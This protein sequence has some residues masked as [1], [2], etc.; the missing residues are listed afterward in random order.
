[1]EFWKAKYSWVGSN[2][3]RIWFLARCTFLKTRPPW[4]TS[5]PYT[6]KP[7]H[8]RSEKKKLKTIDSNILYQPLPW[9]LNTEINT[10]GIWCDRWLFGKYLLPSLSP[11]IS[12]QF[13]YSLPL[14]PT[15]RM[16]TWLLDI[17]K[18]SKHECVLNCFH[19]WHPSCPLALC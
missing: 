12:Q 2:M 13:L 16:T 9:N 17:R 10:S 19:V 7:T 6:F 14:S 4:R 11:S 8:C 15:L 3:L 5:A 18:V 1:M